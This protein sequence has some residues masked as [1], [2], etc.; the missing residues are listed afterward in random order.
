M[1][2][3]TPRLSMYQLRGRVGGFL[4]L[5]FAVALIIVVAG[6]DDLRH[7]F[8]SK[9]IFKDKKNPYVFNGEATLN[10]RNE[11]LRGSNGFAQSITSSPGL[12]S[13]NDKDVYAIVFDAGST[14]SR[15]HVFKFRILPG[16]LNI[17]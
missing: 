17:V 1:L 16:M 13:K 6:Y 7:R 4:I 12:P 8:V 10:V 5:V 15:V 14:G 3:S 9:S 11:N 2:N